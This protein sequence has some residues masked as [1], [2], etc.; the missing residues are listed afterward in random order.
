MK[1]LLI[2]LLFI[3]I[4][5]SVSCLTPAT[6]ANKPSLYDAGQDQKVANLEAIVLGPNGL[7]AIVGAQATKL[8]SI[9]L[10][11]DTSGLTAKVNSMETSLATEVSKTT[12]LRQ[13]LDAANAKIKTLEDWKAGAGTTTA[14]G[15]TT[16][17]TSVTGLVAFVTNPIS[18]P[19]MY[20]ASTGGSA[21]T[22]YTMRIT[23]QSTTWQYVK[24]ILT[25]N[26]APSYSARALTGITI[27]MSNGQC[28][29]TGSC[30]MN[31]PLTSTLGNFSISPNVGVGATVTSG[32][33]II[34]ISGCN[35]TG[36][37]QIGAG[38]VMDIL[39]QISGVTTSEVTLWNITH[40]ISARSM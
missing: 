20:S 39:I 32:V 27:T 35:A 11:G 2:A 33:V 10:G 22:F 5:V 28:N 36:E 1:R 34:P 19:Q 21:S 38:Q 16:V 14:T 4:V 31:G 15:G 9:P 30:A 18:I 29:L 17:P 12:T 26:I 37:F 7:Q 24:P 6:T 40:S 3:V 25:M 23:N 8:A 13:D